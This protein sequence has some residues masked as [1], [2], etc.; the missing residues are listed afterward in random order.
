MR[1]FSATPPLVTLAPPG[2]VRDFTLFMHG[3]RSNGIAPGQWLP[4]GKPVVQLADS[5]IVVTRGRRDWVTDLAC[6]L[7]YALR[8]RSL[9]ERLCR[10]EIG[11]SCHGSLERFLVWRRLAR[12]FVLAWLGA[13]PWSARLH[14]TS[15]LPGEQACRVEL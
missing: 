12:E 6:S 13:W 10:F 1:D 5:G 3:G 9:V 11:G 2:A 4:A 8:A 15:A 7:E 14:R